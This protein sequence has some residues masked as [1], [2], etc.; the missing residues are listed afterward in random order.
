MEY[1]GYSL[2]ELVAKPVEGTIRTLLVEDWYHASWH[3]KQTNGL[4]QVCHKYRVRH[5]I[6]VNKH[7]C[8]KLKRLAKLGSDEKIS[9]SHLRSIKVSYIHYSPSEILAALVSCSKVVAITWKMA[10]RPDGN[11]SACMNAVVRR[12]KENRIFETFASVRCVRFEV[13][14]LSTTFDYTYVVPDCIDY[15]ALEGWLQRNRKAFR[16]CKKVVTILLGL[17]KRRKLQMDHNLVN[18]IVE[19]V[20]ETRGTQVWTSNGGPK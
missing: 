13:P 8:V 4:L 7:E 14:S 17:N 16:N 6:F 5:L 9:L 12:L 3:S 10:R 1:D 18:P 15:Y 20:W 2:A 19:M 11:Y